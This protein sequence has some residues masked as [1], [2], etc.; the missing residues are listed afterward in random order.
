MSVSIGG[1]SYTM[2][3][4]SDVDRD[5]LYLELFESSLDCPSL[6][7]AFYSD[8]AHT[9]VFTAFRKDLPL[10]TVEWIIDRVKVR[11]RSGMSRARGDLAGNGKRPG[12]RLRKARTVDDGTASANSTPRTMDNG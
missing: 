9:M 3:R 5:S 4:G 2:P 1:L 11:L 7:E 6:A 10:E 12:A 8:Q